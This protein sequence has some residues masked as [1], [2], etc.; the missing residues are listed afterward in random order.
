MAKSKVAISLDSSTLEQL[1]RLIE[2]SIFPNRSQAIQVAID[3]KLKRLE[4][5]R[6]ARECA[7]LDP[8]FEKA[9]AEEG[10]SEEL[11]EW[12]EY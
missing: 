11:S 9:L 12:P 1:D 4:G 6:L 10:L 7:K 3:E 2:A 5:S 8:T